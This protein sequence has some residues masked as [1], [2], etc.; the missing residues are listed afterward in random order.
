MDV[1]VVITGEGQYF[2]EVMLN[3]TYFILIYRGK[4][5]NTCHDFTDEAEVDTVEVE[6]VGVAAAAMTEM[7]TAAVAMV[8]TLMND[9]QD[10][11]PMTDQLTAAEELQNIKGQ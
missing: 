3:K 6:A 11:L 2:Y 8:V 7:A 5:I 9:P 4:Y 1:A 10:T